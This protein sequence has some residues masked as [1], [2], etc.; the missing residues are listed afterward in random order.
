[1]KV[2]VLFSIIVGKLF[3]RLDGAQRIDENAAAADLDLAIGSAGVVDEASRV[4]R[5][6]SIDHARVTRPEQ[7]LP[8]IVRNLFGCG[9]AP[10]VF[11]H[12]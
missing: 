5:N 8:T 7:V 11:D 6:I 1:M 3:A 2:E 10:E 9:G 4:R 12:E